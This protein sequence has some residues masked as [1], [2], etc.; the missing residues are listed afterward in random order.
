MLQLVIN[1]SYY[2]TVAGCY[3]TC[4]YVYKYTT[5]MTCV[6]YSLGVDR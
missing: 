1:I 6:V 5:N 3:C 4:L 2:F